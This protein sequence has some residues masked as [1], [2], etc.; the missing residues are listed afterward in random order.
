MHAALFNA[1]HVQHLTARLAGPDLEAGFNRLDTLNH[2]IAAAMEGQLTPARFGTLW[3]KR[4]EDLTY[5]RQL[6]AETVANPAREIMLY[7]NVATR[8][9][10]NYFEARLA[11]LTGKG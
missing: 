2:L 1:P 8:L 3:R 9:N 7:R 5:L 11:E 6:Q 4:R 10:Q